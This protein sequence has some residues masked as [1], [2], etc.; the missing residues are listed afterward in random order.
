MRF[1]GFYNASYSIM[2]KFQQSFIMKWYVAD[3]LSFSYEIF[4]LNL[5][6]E[7]SRFKKIVALCSEV[8]VFGMI[9]NC[10]S[11]SLVM[12]VLCENSFSLLF[13]DM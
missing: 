6:E 12:N 5:F 1:S 7:I 2:Y 3:I 11:S 9:G 8:L 4:I 13:V 10:T